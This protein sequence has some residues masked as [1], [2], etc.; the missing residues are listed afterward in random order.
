MNPRIKRLATDWKTYTG[1]IAAVVTVMAAAPGFFENLTKGIEALHKTFTELHK[2]SPDTRWIAVALFVL[3]TVIALAAAWSR[4]SV[5]LRPERFILSADD[6]RHLVGRDQK[7][8]ALADVC[9]HHPVVFLQGESGAG[10]S[11]LVQAGLLPFYLNTSPDPRPNPPRLLPVRIDAS[12]LAWADG[13]RVELARVVR[14]LSDPERSQ[15]G[16]VKPL[17]SSDVF[18]WLAELPREAA[19]QLL[20]VLDQIDDYAVAHREHFVSGDT[21]VSPEAFQQASAEWTAVG[22]LV[23]EGKI[24]LLVVCRSDAAGILDALRFDQT[25]TFLLPRIEPKL[26]SPVLDTIAAD[27][28][29]GDVVADPECGWY[30]LKERLLRD[31]SVGGTLV[32]PVQLAVALDSLRRFRFL[33]PLEYAKSGGLRGLERLHIQ[34]HV[35]EAAAAVGSDEVA[36]LRGLMCL[37]TEDGSKT[38]RARVAEVRA[39]VGGKAAS[40]NGFEVLVD[41]LVR[42]R[43][44]RQQT[45][46]DGD[47]LLLH[48]DYLARGVR[49]AYRQTN[50]WEELLRERGQEF[51]HAFGWRQR[52]RALLPLSAQW[53]LGAARVRRRFHYG[54]YRHFA[55]WSLLRLAPVLLLAA[56]SGVAGWWVDAVRQASIAE[57]ILTGISTDSRMSAAEAQEWVNLAAARDAARFHAMQIALARESIAP[58]VLSRA[59]LFGHAVVGLDPSGEISQRV[60][61]KFILPSLGRATMNHECISACTVIPYLRL[62]PS[63]SRRAAAAL[64]ERMKTEKDSYRLASLGETLGAL[65]AKLEAK[66]VQPLAA[67]L[68][69][70]MKTEKDS[71]SLA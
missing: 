52:W 58:K 10:K 24:H 62:A 43:I 9:E 69:E 17:D 65:S 3:L 40:G 54:Q 5:L 26:I 36:L 42:G 18:K 41:H 48:H 63:D 22:Q 49:E 61:D 14:G 30:Q 64:V 2:L 46:E 57:Q 59:E 4:K 50:Y 60:F 8:K 33:T 56:L 51:S 31:V 28:H 21:V 6:P 19:R 68:V 15:L 7:V 35:R 67:A 71:Y 16:A 12:S 37:V 23:R 53:R 66:D 45:A 55:L 13:L 38:R 34:R 70:R 25:S 1:I 47:Y 20:V 44:L 27:D 32:L 39:A 29:K 11:A